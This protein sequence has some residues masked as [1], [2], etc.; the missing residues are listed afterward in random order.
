M[1]RLLVLLLFAPAMVFADDDTPRFALRAPA[2]IEPAPATDG[3]FALKA[4]FASQASAGELREGGRFRVIG[5]IAQRGAIACGT[6]E[7]FADG[8]EN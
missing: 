1:R 4:R 3:T 7:I 6:P 8:F 2:T 5:R